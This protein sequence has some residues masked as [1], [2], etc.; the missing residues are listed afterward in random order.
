MSSF[1]STI[2][3]MMIFIVLA[4]LFSQWS[5]A[6]DIFNFLSPDSPMTSIEVEG[7][8]LP[9]AK[10]DGGT[11]KTQVASS[12]IGINQRVYGSKKHIVVVGAKYQKLDLTADSPFLRD[13]YNEQVSLSYKQTLP[14]NKFWLG[15]V[16]YGSASDRPFKS[17]HDNTLS[18]NY[19]QKTSD[20]WFFVANY[21]NNRPF[22]NNIPLP[23]FFYVKEMSIEK[24]FIVGFPILFWQAP[25][26]PDFSLRY[27]GLIP[28]SHKLRLLYTKW[29]VYSPYIGF[30]QSPQN[31]FRHDREDRYDRFFWFE[32]RLA[33]GLEG[34]AVD[35]MRFDLSSGL[36]F[37]RQFFEAR[38]FLQ[39]KKNVVDLE[40]SFFVALTVRYNFN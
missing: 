9:P 28:F 21:S 27:F 32:R 12:A 5:F 35:G 19:I 10:I 22:L 37:D 18:A 40:K 33:L 39:K 29:R 24:T 2:F 8:F 36:A 34:R 30:E 4:M 14:D 25:I 26:S 16:S 38:N 17:S 23:G 31:Y 6:Q 3:I 7:A 15:S 11:D 20:R 1:E 13:Y